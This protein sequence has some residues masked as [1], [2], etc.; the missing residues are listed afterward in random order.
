MQ[1]KSV[2]VRKT[3]IIKSDD[4]CW[5][6]LLESSSEAEECVFNFYIYQQL[7]GYLFVSQPVDKSLYDDS[8][9]LLL[10]DAFAE[11]LENYC[12]DLAEWSD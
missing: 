8:L 11:A 7:D 4:G 1:I 3:F 10:D 9:H 2:L 12:I 5:G 6:P